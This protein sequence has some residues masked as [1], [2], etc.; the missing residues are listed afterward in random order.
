MY[1]IFLNYL[2][3]NTK[4]GP[5]IIGHLYGSLLYPRRYS[6]R[7]VSAGGGGSLLY[8]IIINNL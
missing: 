1:T 7:K 8:M 6:T 3:E 2:L 5:P 4:V